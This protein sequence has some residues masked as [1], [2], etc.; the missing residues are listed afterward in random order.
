MKKVNISVVNTGY[1]PVPEAADAMNAA[2]SEA[3]A[4]KYI[5]AGIEKMLGYLDDA[6]KAGTDLVC[7]HEDF[8]SVSTY[9]RDFKHEGLFEH[10]VEKT[11]MT[12]RERTS[13]LAKQHSMHIAANN[14]EIRDGCVYNTTT[15]Y[16]RDG[17]IIGQYRKVH[18]A[19][20]EN[21]RA[22]PGETFDVFPT[23]IGNIGFI[24]CYDMIFPEACR[25]LTLNGADIVVLPTQGWGT[26]GKITPIVGEALF[27][28]RAAE[29]SVYFVV[30]KVLYG[31]EADGGRSMI[32][33]NYGNIIAQGDLAKEGIVSAVFESNYALAD[34]Y[35]FNNFYAGAPGCKVRMLKARK[36]WLYGALTS[37]DTPFLNANVS[38][39]PLYMAEDGRNVMEK[40]ENMPDSEKQKYHW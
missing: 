34:P 36:P 16:G 15:L 6:G 7:T 22:T 17:A 3:G 11:Y 1:L 33:D 5:S 26:G 30:A 31:P 4:F 38:Y 8:P 40:W 37:D 18:L 14:F 39:K 20:S 10:L 13:A 27:R 23:D 19:D 25:S 29:N 32:L 28:T 35:D 12:I 9:L 21:W 24:I 2:F